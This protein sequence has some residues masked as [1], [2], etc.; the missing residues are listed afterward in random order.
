MATGLLEMLKRRELRERNVYNQP[1]V[2]RSHNF[3]SKQ[4]VAKTNRKDVCQLRC[5]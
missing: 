1:I 2:E 5:P 4:Y 3:K